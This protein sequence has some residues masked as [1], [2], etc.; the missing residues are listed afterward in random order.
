MEVSEGEGWA[1]LEEDVADDAAAEGG[2]ECKAEGADNVVVVAEARYANFR[3][4][5][6]LLRAA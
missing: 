2:D 4:R 5:R 6:A 3:R 1:V